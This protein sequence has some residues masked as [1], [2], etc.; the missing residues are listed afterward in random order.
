[1]RFCAVTAAENWL[2]HGGVFTSQHESLSP[3]TL[4]RRLIIQMIKDAVSRLDSGFRNEGSPS[5]HSPQRRH[6]LDWWVS[7]VVREAVHRGG[8]REEADGREKAEVAETG[9]SKPP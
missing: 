4:K 3:L 2:Q 9:K 6:T 5:C 8:R 7:C 1:M